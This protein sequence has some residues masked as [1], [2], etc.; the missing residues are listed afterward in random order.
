[1]PTVHQAIAAE[2]ASARRLKTAIIARKIVDRRPS[3]AMAIVMQVRTNA[4]VRRTAASILIAKQVSATTAWTMIVMVLQT[5]GTPLV[6]VIRRAMV[7]VVKGARH[8]MQMTN[9]VPTGV[10]G[11]NVNRNP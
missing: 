2:T 5:A 1:V 8:A 6:R 3:A 11:E 7:R 10:T 9:V 4:T